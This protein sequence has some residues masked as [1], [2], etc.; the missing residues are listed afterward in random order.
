MVS[1]AK[2]EG[3]SLE[4][5]GTYVFSDSQLQDSLFILND[6][7]YR[8]KYWA[9]ENHQ[10]EVEGKW[11]YNSKAEE[12]LFKEFVFF[13]NEGPSTPP[14]NWFSKVRVTEGH[15]DLMYSREDNIFYRKVPIIQIE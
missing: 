3:G 6:S 15:I 2:K 13:N 8:Y 1:C 10:F 7:I 9:S 4:Y 11:I 14:G 5:I 12:I